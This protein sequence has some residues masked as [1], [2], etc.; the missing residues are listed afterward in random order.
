MISAAAL[1]LSFSAGSHGDMLF[2][3]DMSPIENDPENHNEEDNPPGW[4]GAFGQESGSHPRV[5]W[6]FDE[7]RAAP[8]SNG[9][10]LEGNQTEDGAHIRSVGIPIRDT[11]KP[12]FLISFNL[13]VGEGATGTLDFRFQQWNDGW[14]YPNLRLF[15]EG[16]NLIG[17]EPME[18][19]YGAENLTVTDIGNGWRNVS[20]T[21]TF[22]TGNDDGILWFEP[23]N[24]G[25]FQGTYAIDNVSLEAIPE[26]G[27]YALF[28]GLLA[29]GACLVRRRMKRSA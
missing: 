25:G 24:G 19:H 15:G 13:M 21:G 17:D 3:T 27:T 26:P 1:L 11:D 14:Q 2:S 22:I 29:L 5:V 9:Y 8:G 16:N 18:N 6:E 12:D 23:W 28:G 20:V 10:F 4:G 7:S